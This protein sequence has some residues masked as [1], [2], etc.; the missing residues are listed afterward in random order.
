MAMRRCPWMDGMSQG[1]MD[2]DATIPVKNLTMQA[3]ACFNERFKHEQS[4]IYI[5]IRFRR[6]P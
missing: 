3:F 1:A 2:G 4:P 5:R 6:P